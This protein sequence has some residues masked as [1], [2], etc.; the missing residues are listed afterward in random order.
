MTRNPNN[1]RKR[2]ARRRAAATGQSYTQAR[3][4]SAPDSPAPEPPRS[5]AGASG[6]WLDLDAQGNSFAWSSPAPSTEDAEETTNV[7]AEFRLTPLSTAATSGPPPY[8]E[9]RATRLRH[10]IQN[11]RLE[12]PPLIIDTPPSDDRLL[13]LDDDTVRRRA[14]EAR[15]LQWLRDTVDRLAAQD[16]E[17]D[18]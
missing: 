12:F 1:A 5:T 13:F 8:D 15:D 6:L 18:Q 14:S 16:Q 4:E 9:E 2:E 10:T 17:P 11:T 7:I 3:R